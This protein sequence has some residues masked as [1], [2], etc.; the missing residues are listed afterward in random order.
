MAVT[1]GN[2]TGSYRRYRRLQRGKGQVLNK[3]YELT[4]SSECYRIAMV[5]HPGFKLEYFKTHHWQDE[6]IETA[7]T[8]VRNEYDLNYKH[9][10]AAVDQDDHDDVVPVA[11]R[12]RGDKSASS[13]TLW[14]RRAV[15]VTHIELPV[16]PVSNRPRVEWLVAGVSSSSRCPYRA[17]RVACVKPTASAMPS[18]SLRAR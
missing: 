5:L 11:R 4:D 1:D 8:L 2:M 16:S 12:S 17:A 14:A 6:W 7:K 18:G 9:S 10:D 3:Y 13:G 15:R